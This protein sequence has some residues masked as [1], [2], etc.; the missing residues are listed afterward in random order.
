[1]GWVERLHNYW[2]GLNHRRLVLGLLT[3][4]GVILAV[5]LI[6]NLDSLLRLFGSRAAL[7]DFSWKGVGN[8]TAGRL[9]PPPPGGRVR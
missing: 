4:L 2:A 5:F 7:D 6:T 1:M 8:M 3:V 9:R